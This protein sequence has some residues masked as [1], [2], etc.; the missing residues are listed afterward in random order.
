MKYICTI[1]DVE[2]ESDDEQPVCPVCG[3]SGDQLEV[4]NEG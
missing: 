4:V 1:C 2:F 3:A